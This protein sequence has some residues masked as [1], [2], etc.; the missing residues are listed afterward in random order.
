ML[1]GI[2]IVLPTWLSKN[3]LI[4]KNFRKVYLLGNAKVIKM[5]IFLIII[6]YLLLYCTSIMTKVSFTLI[7]V[8]QKFK[9]YKDQ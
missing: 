2:K 4:N 9:K 7:R 8:T 1:L 5:Y 3:R 6:R